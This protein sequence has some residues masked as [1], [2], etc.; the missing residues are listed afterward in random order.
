MKVIGIVQPQAWLVINEY[1]LEVDLLE[2]TNYRGEV[3]IY[4]RPDP[5][6][7]EDFQKFKCDCKRL[8]I[9]SY[10]LTGDFDVGGFIGTATLTDCTVSATGKITAILDS[11][12]E[13]GFFP[14]DEV[15]NFFDFTGNP[16]AGV[17]TARQNRK[18]PKRTAQSATKS[19][20]PEQQPA[21]SPA[22]KKQV[23]IDSAQKSYARHFFDGVEEQLKSKLK[24][25]LKIMGRAVAKDAVAIT[26][27][28][29]VSLFKGG[30][31]KNSRRR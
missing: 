4:A 16:F 13:Q 15:S 17:S 1:L 7:S 18:E 25:D 23:K 31:P 30:N 20:Y 26:S 19:K 29:V 27:E 6:S 22:S 21:P 5:V 9:K 10:P 11:P 14:F 3:L 8:G 2:F 12:V 24:K 28:F